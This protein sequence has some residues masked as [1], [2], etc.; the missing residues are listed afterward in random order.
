M[1]LCLARAARREK[2]AER[3]S[4]GCAGVQSALGYV[5]QELFTLGRQTPPIAGGGGR[6]LRGRQPILGVV[7]HPMGG[8]E[9]EKECG[10]EF[11]KLVVRALSRL[12]GGG[13]EDAALYGAPSVLGTQ[14]DV[15]PPR[16][17]RA[18][19][20]PR[21]ADETR[22]PRPDRGRV[23]VLQGLAVAG[24]VRTTV[25]RSVMRGLLSHEV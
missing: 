25:R 17:Q 15:H 23:P 11:L 7:K 12:P 24:E 9:G 14:E 19:W 5:L 8:L 1:I 18:K 2:V 13:G 4:G 6:A 21:G 16:G 20:R 10:F 3:V 22:R